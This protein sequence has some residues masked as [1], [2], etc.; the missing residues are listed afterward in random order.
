[1]RKKKRKEHKKP[2]HVKHVADAVLLEAE[3]LAKNIAANERTMHLLKKENAVYRKQLMDVM[4][5]YRIPYLNIFL[6]I[7]KGV[8][9]MYNIEV[10]DKRGSV[11]VDIGLRYFLR[12]A[13][14]P[15]IGNRTIGISDKEARNKI[16]KSLSVKLASL[17]RVDAFL[18]TEMRKLKWGTKLVKD[19][20]TKPIIRVNEGHKNGN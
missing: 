18:V 12:R 1:M 5:A 17:L 9:E 14:K 3:Q 4:L 13:L 19:K 8:E 2:T 15:H 20:L 6:H 16:A 10:I 7:K 11:P